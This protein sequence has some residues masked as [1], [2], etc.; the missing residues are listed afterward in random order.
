MLRRL[1]PDPDI[2]LEPGHRV[3]DVPVEMA[4]L[5]AELQ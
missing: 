3:P 5:G 2:E 1:L 4:Y